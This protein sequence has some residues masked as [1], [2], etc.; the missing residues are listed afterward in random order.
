[1][2]PQIARPVRT[3]VSSDEAGAGVAVAG[4]WGDVARDG[5]ALGA[6]AGAGV[7]GY[8]AAREALPL[9]VMAT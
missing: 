6:T 5:A 7:V 8:C 2:P 3:L 9:G 4:C 1:M